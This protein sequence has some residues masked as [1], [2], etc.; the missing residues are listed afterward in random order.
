MPRF[1]AWMPA[2]LLLVLLPLSAGCA[3]GRIVDGVYRD[4]TH[5]FQV[6]LPHG[7]VPLDLKGAALAYRDPGL[8]AALALRTGCENPES[9]TLSWVARHLYFGLKNPRILQQEDIRL[10]GD[11]GVRVHLLATLDGAPVEVEGVT[12]RHHGCL[13]DFMYVAPP[14][15]FVRGRPVFER[16]PQ[17]LD[18]AGRPV[19]RRPPR[20]LRRV[21]RTGAGGAYPSGR[22]RPKEGGPRRRRS[23]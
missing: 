5:D 8:G 12:L 23:S 13:L 11:E 15:S 1:S 7:W 17:Q 21:G 20:A 6:G 3:T 2:G 16:L 4:I 10:H 18:A 19:I 9:G 22:T 14:D